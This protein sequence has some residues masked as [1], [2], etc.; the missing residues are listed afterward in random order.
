[1]LLNGP[2]STWTRRWRK[3]RTMPP[4]LAEQL[5]PTPVE[6]AGAFDALSCVKRL[7][8]WTEPAT[9]GEWTA[10]RALING[11]LVHHTHTAFEETFAHA[12]RLADWE[13]GEAAYIA[14][15]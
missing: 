15:R 7:R 5:A 14:R 4:K 9:E 13:P 6:V 2:K 3:D 1:M 10:Y 12:L 11:L 8:Q